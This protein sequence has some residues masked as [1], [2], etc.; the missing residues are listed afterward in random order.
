MKK[1]SNVLI[2]GLLLISSFVVLACPS[3][4]NSSPTPPP[5]AKIIGIG[6]HP[7]T[8]Q[9]ISEAVLGDEVALM[10]Q[11][12]Y[13]N[14]KMV[15]VHPLI[16]KKVEFFVSEGT[17]IA[18]IN[19]ATVKFNKEG[20]FKLEV[21]YDAKFFN[22][23]TNTINSDPAAITPYLV[24]IE[25]ASPPS[26]TVRVG[27]TITLPQIKA[28]YSDESEKTD[29]PVYSVNKPS[30]A[31]LNGKQLEGIA[32]GDVI[33]TATYTDDGKTKTVESIISIIPAAAPVL[34][35]ITLSTSAN[36]VDEDKTLT[37]T[38]TATYDDGSTKLV[39]PTYSLD[40]P[41]LG[42]FT[43][44][45]FKPASVTKNEEVKITAVYIEESIEKTAD[46]TI[47][48]I[49]NISK[50]LV[51]IEVNN[52]PSSV[53]VG[54]TLSL[55]SAIATYSDNTTET[56]TPN[57]TS[58]NSNIASISGKVLTGVSAGTVSVTASYEHEGI[59]KTTSFD[60]TVKDPNSGGDGDVGF[61]F[62]D[63]NSG[64]N[65]GDSG[66]GGIEFDFNN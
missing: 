55:P 51:K 21:I 60:V 32:V 36:T 7:D 46:K 26:S 25:F 52:P 41:S 28:V 27:S 34:T 11:L 1:L 42:S 4:T 13:S 23:I 17:D 53:N 31:S 8:V 24:S 44:G 63:P 56:I 39:N 20:K 29:D 54:S 10:F 12:E 65:N 61:N 59:I 6:F 18:E 33:V 50:T 43:N 66:D 58:S 14:G 47:T 16:D 22:K 38:T 9:E 62:G 40:K 37:L 30:L 19:E 48:I 2:F 49:N 64:G 45:V 15:D 5:K 35:S 3:N 57:Y